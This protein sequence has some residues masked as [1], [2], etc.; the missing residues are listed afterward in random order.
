MCYNRLRQVGEKFVGKLV[1]NG[2]RLSKVL[3]FFGPLE[4]ILWHVNLDGGPQK[5]DGGMG[6]AKLDLFVCV[7]ELEISV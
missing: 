4:L 1:W 5:T 3:S 2:Y 7:M 6:N